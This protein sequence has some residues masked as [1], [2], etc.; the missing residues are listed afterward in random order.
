MAGNRKPLRVLGCQT[1]VPDFSSLTQRDRHVS[2]LCDR[3][4]KYLSE[5][6]PVDLVVL[7]ELVTIPYSRETFESLPLFAET[8]SGASTEAFIELSQNS[9]FI[10]LV[11][12]AL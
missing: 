11:W 3:I 12:N 8:L 4:S 1:L 2:E 5:R 6:T 7:P 10:Y 9:K